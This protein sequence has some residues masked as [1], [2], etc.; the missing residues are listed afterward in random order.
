MN[1]IKIAM[2]CSLLFLIACGEDEQVNTSPSIVAPIDDL[3]TLEG[4]SETT[5]SLAGVFEDAD[6]DALTIE[7]T[8][9][10]PSVATVAVSGTLL[11]ITEVA[12]GTTSVTVTAADGKGGTVAAIFDVIITA[13]ANDNSINLVNTVCDNTPSV[14]NA[15]TET[16]HTNGTRTI[17]TNRVP[18]HDYGNQIAR[19]GVRDLVS[20]SETFTFT[21][22]PA[23]ANRATSIL[24]SSNRPAYSYGIALNGVPIDPAP[25]EPFIFE[26]ASGEYNWDWVFEPTNNR[27]AVGLDCNTAHL[28]PTSNNTLG[29]IHYHGDM[30]VYANSLL[31]GL[32]D[33]TTTPNEPVQ[34]G[35]AA[36]GFPIVYKF[37][38]AASGVGVQSLTSSYQLKDGYRPG[39]GDSAPCGTY[40]GKYTNDY[41]YV[42][43]AG[44]LDEC[45]GIMRSITL[46][47]PSGATETFG[48]FYVI[49]DDFPIIGRCLSGTPA[50]VFSKTP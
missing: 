6:G 35:W 49:T 17:V 42:S 8:S 18:D 43:G 44:D 33:G 14:A 31:S 36:D 11:S 16:R 39:D 21:S 12:I 4:F 15:Y 7:A 28:Q 27:N 22:S 3:T 32:G 48:Y 10:T 41:E 47:T 34:V 30:T 37:G 26:D 5:L 2:G 38:P 40:S 9:S 29:L 1:I 45:N 23:L 24:T 20:T 50:D 19:L 13:C 25:A 46:T